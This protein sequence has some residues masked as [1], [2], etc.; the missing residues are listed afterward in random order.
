MN[1]SALE[2]WKLWHII[3]YAVSYDDRQTEP[4]WM[5]VL[6]V[7]NNQPK[8]NRMFYVPLAPRGHVPSLVRFAQKKY[9]RRGNDHIGTI[10]DKT[11]PI[12][13]LCWGGRN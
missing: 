10:P 3:S 7:K 5:V 4:T 13:R 11:M 2:D 12:V 8:S 6:T 9:M 1:R